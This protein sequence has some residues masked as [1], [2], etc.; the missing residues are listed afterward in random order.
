MS[1]RAFVVLLLTAGLLWTG[2][3]AWSQTAKKKP[4]PH[5]DERRE[6]EAVQEA[7]RDL[8]EARDHQKEAEKELLAEQVKARQAA[9]AHKAATAALRK[10]EDRLESEHGEKTG[11]TA[12]RSKLREAQAELD[13]LSKPIV[14]R[15]HNEQ[16][17]LVK[18]VERARQAIK[19]RD[20]ESEE[21]RSAAVAEHAKLTKQLREL[22]RSALETDATVKPLLARVEAAEAGVQAAL[23]K[24]ESAVER[25]PELK[26]ARKAI[27][28]AKRDLEAAE[29]AVAKAARAVAEA[30][31]KVAQANQKLNQKVADDMRDRNPKKKKG[32]K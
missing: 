4:S 11:L 23:K 17:A 26:S 22:E 8:Q 29:N 13:R 2:E 3:A 7:Q 5:E 18:A 30:R 28:A 24:F 27:D 25:D 19:P 20:D 6:N 10:I 31:N 14:E 15:V 12:A 1:G 9:A 32:G 21:S 16:S